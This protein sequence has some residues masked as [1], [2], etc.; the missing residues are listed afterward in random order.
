MQDEIHAGKE[1]QART[2]GLLE[3]ERLEVSHLKS[4]VS[5]LNVTITGHKE[6]IAE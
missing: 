6:Q 4:E 1:L 5:S 2:E 3:K